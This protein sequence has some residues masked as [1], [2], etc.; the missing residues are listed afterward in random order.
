MLAQ[1]NGDSAPLSFNLT[2]TRGLVA[3]VVSRNAEVGIDAE[4][5]DRRTDP[6]ELAER[7]FSPLEVVTLA[8]CRESVHVRFLEIWTLKEAYLKALGEGLSTPLHQFAF[9]LEDM[10]AMRFEPSRALA[11]HAWSFTLFAI[12]E[13]YRIA[14]AVRGEPPAR[15]RLVVSSD[16]AMADALPIRMWNNEAQ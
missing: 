2:H 1:E 16:P 15:Y 4:T 8:H 7:F 11:S 10:S 14:V 9:L 12:S 6:L 13:C 5:L 3:C